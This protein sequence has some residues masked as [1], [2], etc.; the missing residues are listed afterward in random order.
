MDKSSPV[1]ENFENKMA[2]MSGGPKI[3]RSTFK[4][5]AGNLERR[6]ANNEKKITS[7]KNI[8]KAQKI[9]I[10]EKISPKSSPTEILTETNQTLIQIKEQ[11]EIDFLGREKLEKQRLDLEKKLELEKNR[12]EKEN[13]IEKV[14]KNNSFIKGATKKIIKPFGNIFDKF[15]ELEG[16][17]GTGLLINNAVNFFKNP[18]NVEKIQKIFNWTTKNWKKLVAGAGII[19]G[20]K[21]AAT[22]TGI[23]TAAGS[24]LSILGNPL[25]LVGAGI[26]IA[27]AAQGFGK[28]Q[29]AV[30]QELEAMGGVT[31]ENRKILLN[32]Y[33]Q[34]SDKLGKFDSRQAEIKARIKFLETGNYSYAGTE[35]KFDFGLPFYYKMGQG[36]GFSF[37]KPKEFANGGYT[38]EDGGIVHP[39]EYVFNPKRTKELGQEFLDFLHY[40]ADLNMPLPVYG[41]DF[42]IT[43]LP[44]IDLTTPKIEKTT[45]NLPATTVARVNSTN[46]SNL[47]MNEVPVLFGFNDLVYT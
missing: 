21:L 7:I 6:V 14:K 15:I 16:I 23:V 34:L 20:L 42:E 17:L 39:Y 46:S 45:S 3:N 44:M 26:L 35:F 30:V 2:A 29:K 37:E 28:S 1:F 31:D 22:L 25:V 9:N 24:F 13:E 12:G 43:E 36:G 33:R 4:I 10:G 32:S 18:E 11:L 38:G 40:G 47:Y 5:G 8:F 41:Q 27:A 19:V